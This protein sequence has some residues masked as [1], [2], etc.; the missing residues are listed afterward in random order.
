[1]VVRSP[2]LESERRAIYRRYHGAE[3]RVGIVRSLIL[4]TT[5]FAFLDLYLLLASTRS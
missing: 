4:A 5:A 2:W 3:T 1:M